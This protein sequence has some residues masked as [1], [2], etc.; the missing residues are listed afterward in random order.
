MVII[1]KNKFTNNLRLQIWERDKGICQHCKKQL[2]ELIEP[3]KDA[4]K[5]LLDTTEI[6]IYK[7]SHNC[8]K[9]GKE[10]DI[11]TYD[12]VFLYNHSIGDIEKLDRML[13]DIYPF[14]KMVYS[15]TQ[16]QN[17]IGNTCIHCGAYQGNFFISQQLLHQYNSKGE[18]EITDKY[19]PNTLTAEDFPN[20]EEE[21]YFEKQTMEGHIHHIDGC[22]ENN[23]VTNLV[24][25]CRNCHVQ[26]HMGLRKR[27][28]EEKG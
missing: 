22:R 11:V 23:D 13:I 26:E 3:R 12:I 24:L 1:S 2:T 10:T 6:P 20:D 25:L 9:C 16:R 15:K 21:K 5:E 27:K 17:V 4:E 7:W 19:I 28:L 14:V 18:E 8:W